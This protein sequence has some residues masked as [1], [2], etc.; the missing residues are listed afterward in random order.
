MLGEWVV[1]SCCRGDTQIQPGAKFCTRNGTPVG[2]GGKGKGKG[3]AQQRPTAGPSR[4]P[5]PTPS[6]RQ[7]AL[8]VGINYV[9]TRAQLRGCVN[10]VRAIEGLL[11]G[12]GWQRSQVRTLI[13]GEALCWG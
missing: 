2:S 12:L 5:A 9:G 3:S 7:R 13:D 4:A 8:L 11:G 1:T 10:D 6:G